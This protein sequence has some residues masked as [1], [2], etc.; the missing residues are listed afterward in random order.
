MRV[1]SR[2]SYQS[3][4]PIKTQELSFRCEDDFTGSGKAEMETTAATTSAVET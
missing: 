4:C 1:S 3:L 2:L